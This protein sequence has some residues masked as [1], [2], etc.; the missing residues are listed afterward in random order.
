MF[1]SNSGMSNQNEDNYPTFEDFLI[2]YP[3]YQDATIKECASR[4]PG[5]SSYYLSK[6][7]IQLYCENEKCVGFRF[8]EC[9]TNETIYID[10]VN[11]KKAFL[12]YRCKNC[13]EETK[14]FAIMFVLNEDGSSAKMV[15]I[16]EWPPFSP[17]LPSRVV[18]LIGPDKDSFLKGRRSENQGL[19]IGAFS[20]Y[21]RVI[22]N[23]K[24][25]IFDEIIRVS[26]R[27][28][29]PKETMEKIKEARDQTQFS[30]SVESIKPCLPEAL[31]IDGNNPLTLLHSA[32]SKGMHAKTDEECLEL[33][34]SIRVVLSEFADRIG[35]ILKERREFDEAVK[36][37][38]DSKSS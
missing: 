16:G 15:K 38:H 10:Q 30:S 20:Y 36:E 12:D 17:H 19:G 6:P 4:M 21:R 1:H 2:S 13:N 3:P 35:Q 29:V 31:L 5:S 8:F 25:R 32:L 18:S 11:V 26:E 9:I 24:N 37:L 28:K 23:Q 27:L 22:E 14:K 34:K 7:I 33:A